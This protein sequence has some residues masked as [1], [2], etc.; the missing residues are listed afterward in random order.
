MVSIVIAALVA[1]AVLVVIFRVEWRYMRFVSAGAVVRRL[2][3]SP[4]G[5]FSTNIR[6]LGWAWDP[7]PG[8]GRSAN[9][10]RLSGPGR[11]TYTRVSDEEIRVTLEDRDGRRRES[12]GPLPRALVAGT[13]QASRA[14][15]SRRLIWAM[16]AFYPVCGMVGFVIGY[17][18]GGGHDHATRFDHGLVGFVVGFLGV[19]VLLHIVVVV[20]G[21]NGVGSRPRVAARAD[22]E[23]PK[24]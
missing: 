10:G 4:S 14:R 15:R 17:A 20:A 8:S 3:R 21:A 23:R 6:G 18:A 16:F 5:E 7:A 1:V 11:V 12:T 22:E 9:R 24:E 2:Q 13:P 19:A